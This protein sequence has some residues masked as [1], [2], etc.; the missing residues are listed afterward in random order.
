MEWRRAAA[1][2]VAPGRVGS[3]C[4]RWPACRSGGCAADFS[5]TMIYTHVLNLGGMGV[6]S[7]IDTLA[8][9][10]RRLS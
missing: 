9:D 2:P 5:T 4:S 3:S 6:R 1:A 8:L 7:P 10:I